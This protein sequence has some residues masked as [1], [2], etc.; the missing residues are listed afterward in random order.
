MPPQHTLPMPKLR[1]A[2]AVFALL[3]V[4]GSPTAAEA[5]ILTFTD[6]NAFFAALH[7]APRST[8]TYDTGV[9]TIIGNGGTYNGFTYSYTSPVPPA[10]GYGVN[11]VPVRGLIS[12]TYE[13]FGVSVLA[14]TRPSLADSLYGPGERVTAS[15]GRSVTAVGV[16]FNGDPT[17][18]QPGDF[19]IQTSSG[20]AINGNNPVLGDGGGQNMYFVGLISDTPFNSATFGSQ[21]FQLTPPGVAQRGSFS[22]DNLTTAQATLVPAPAAVVVFGGLVVV[23]GFRSRRRR[24]A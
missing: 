7:G 15:F 24:V 1:Q 3:V 19:Y 17:V 20:T 5:G 14:A 6:S 4:V 21:N 12:P 8:E 10:N 9:G 2:A 16:F 11:D 23:A 22:L 18:T 13:G